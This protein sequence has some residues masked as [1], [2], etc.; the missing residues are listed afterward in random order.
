M[1]EIG[2]YFQL[3]QLIDKPYYENFV[4]LNTGRNALLYLVNAKKIRKIYLPYF[5][6]NSVS[7]M[8]NRNKID[9][10][11]YH[12]GRDFLPIF[13]KELR[14][15]EFLYI[16]NYYGQIIDSVIR[17]FKDKYNNIILDNTQSFFQKPI[18]GI[19]TI[20]SCRK[21]F[22][23]PDGAYLSTDVI[24]DERLEKDESSSRM[25]HILGRYEGQASD[26][27]NEF[28]K[29]DESFKELPIK[30]MSK[31]TRNILGAIDYEKIIE[32]RNR[33]LEYLHGRLKH[34]NIL[35]I[36]SPYGP[37]AY[38]Y[39]VENGIEVK[40]KLAQ[41]KIYI[42]TLWPNVLKENRED[43][44]EYYYVANILP[45]SCDQR[46]GTEDMKILLK[47]LEQCID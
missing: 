14:N 1:R 27:Y 8:L 26:F 42:P 39:Y 47:E 6:C 13:D 3:D 41:R 36:K 23:V 38:P 35:D 29:N 15:D 5:L 16:V 7:D 34:T 44:I 17:K 25:K 18:P 43:S 32:S 12:I 40:K 31:L 30:K 9:Y 45:L 20:Y 46:Y 37:F 21:F 22:G 19:D 2:G 24:W 33:N 28:K 11:Y 4:E 10:E